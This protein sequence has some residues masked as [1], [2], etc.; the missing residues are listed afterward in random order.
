[1]LY[2]NN[3]IMNDKYILIDDN[4]KYNIEE[5]IGKMFIKNNEKNISVELSNKLK[6]GY[7][8]YKNLLNYK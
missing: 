1:M 8:G 6:K 3:K 4:I 5:K 2:K 7:F